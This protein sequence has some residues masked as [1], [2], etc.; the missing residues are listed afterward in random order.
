MSRL[1]PWGV[2]LLG[3]RQTVPPS[4]ESLDDFRYANQPIFPTST[5][6]RFLFTGGYTIIKSAAAQSMKNPHA[7]LERFLNLA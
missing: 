5:V 6:S 7:S 2:T 3:K 1:T 4:F